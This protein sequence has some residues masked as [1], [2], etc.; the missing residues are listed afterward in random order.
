M[1]DDQFH[2]SQIAVQVASV[3]ATFI[4]AALAIWGNQLRAWLVG[5]QLSL[6]LYDPQGEAI[7]LTGGAKSRFYHVRVEN[8]RRSAHA[9]NV[10]VVLTKL[11]G[12]AADGSVPV[13]RLSGPVQLTW[14]HGH[15]LPQ[16]ATLGPALNADL[17]VLVNGQNFSLTTFFVPNNQDFSLLA[18]QRIRVELQALSDETESPPLVVDISWDGKWSDDTQEMSKHLVVK[19]STFVDS[20]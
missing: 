15:S 12:P 1:T 8:K 16:F 20:E 19:T 2:I 9:T 17:G 7:N 18:N 14:Q 11:S 13:A 10:R 4:V 6:S 3:L 5:P